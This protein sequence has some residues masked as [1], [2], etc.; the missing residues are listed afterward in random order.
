MRTAILGFPTGLFRFSLFFFVI[1]ALSLLWPKLSS[2]FVLHPAAQPACASLTFRPTAALATLNESGLLLQRLRIGD[3][4]NDGRPD[5]IAAVRLTNGRLFDD[6]AG[7]IAVFLAQANG[8]FQVGPGLQIPGRVDVGDLLLADFNGDGKLDLATLAPGVGL[9]VVRGDGL[10]GFFNPALYNFDST[11]TNGG[12]AALAA[13]DFNGD[14]RTDLAV[15]HSGNNCVYVLFS[16][17]NGFANA[18]RFTVG[19]Q[20]RA[21][22]AGDFNVDGRADLA[23]VN[24][25]SRNVTMLL[26]QAANQ[27]NVRPSFPV[28]GATGRA[29]ADDLNGDGKLDLVLSSNGMTLALL[30]FGDG[31]GGFSAPQPL[32]PP[33]TIYHGYPDINSLVSGDFN[34]DGQRDLALVQ[35]EGVLSTNVYLGLGAGQFAG[36]NIFAAPTLPFDLAVGDLNGDGKQ[37]LAVTG[38]V[39]GVSVNI[40]ALVNQTDCAAPNAPPVFT[41]QQPIELYPPGGEVALGRIQDAETPAAQL[42][43]SLHEAPAGLSFSQFR[44]DVN[45]GWVYAAVRVS[46]QTA[47][48]SYRATLRVADAGGRTAL[49]E[50]TVNV[51]AA[52]SP[53]PLPSLGNDPLTVPLDGSRSFR[54][55]DSLNSPYTGQVSMT[56]SPGFL[57]RVS[58]VSGSYLI[59]NAAPAGA[60]TLTLTAQTICGPP[61]T[62]SY[63]LMVLAL[64]E[65]PAMSFKTTALEVGSTGVLGDFNGDGVLDVASTFY[66]TY[67][68]RLGGFERN[69]QLVPYPNTNGLAPVALDKA[70][71]NGD[72]WLDLAALTQAGDLAILLND[73]T[74]LLQAP[75]LFGVASAYFPPAGLNALVTGDFNGDGRPDLVTVGDGTGKRIGVLLNQG[76]AGLPFD[77]V[78]YFNAGDNL[79]GLAT[80]DF[81]RD[82]KLDLA[83][84]G[85][86][87]TLLLGN[88]DGSF[89]EPQVVANASQ[90]LRHAVGDLNRDGLPDLVYVKRLSNSVAVMLNRGAGT[91][92]EP[93]AYFSGGLLAVAVVIGDLNQ[94]GNADLVVGNNE[95]GSVGI[96]FG[97]GAGDFAAPASYAVQAPL[98]AVALA[99][100][101][102]DGQLD[103][104]ASSLPPKVI[105]GLGQGRFD[106][107]R[108][109]AAGN[110][111]ELIV[112][113]DFTGDGLTDAVVGGQFTSNFLFLFP[114]QADGTFGQRIVLAATPLNEGP[115]FLLTADFDGDRRPDLA[116][117]SKGG[118]V[119]IL[120]NL[121]NGNFSPPGFMT[122]DR[123]ANYLAAADFN[124]D[125]R[126][127]LAVVNAAART[128]SL[129]LNNGFGG[130]AVVTSVAP[131]LEPVSVAGADLNADGKRDLIVAGAKGE[132]AVLPGDG[133]GGFGAATLMTVGTT[134][135]IPTAVGAVERYLLV[136][137]LNGDGK[138]DVVLGDNA[139]YALYVLLGNGAGGFAAPKQLYGTWGNYVTAGDYNGDGKLDLASNGLLLALGDGAGNFRVQQIPDASTNRFFALLDVNRDG[140]PDLLNPVNGGVQ[141][142]LN[143]TACAGTAAPVAAAAVSAA[144]FRGAGLAAEQLVTLFGPQLAVAVRNATAWPLPS[145]LGGTSVKVRDSVGV[146]R[147]A[148]LVFAAPTQLNLMIP[149]GTALGAA[150]IEVSIGDFVSAVAATQIVRVAP[151]LFTADG[152]GRGLPAAQVLRVRAAGSQQYEPVARYD[153]D[154]NRFV[155]VPIVL[156]AANEQVLLVLYGTG[157][158]G[159]SDLSSVA[160]TIGGV[161]VPVQYAGLLTGLAGVD[162]LNLP[163]GPALAGRGLVDVVVR[164]EGQA[165]N[166]VQVQL[167]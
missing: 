140:K 95:S 11:A 92:S 5:L 143:R 96:L 55:F 99:D 47:P 16:T 21:L 13:G 103:L 72:G 38:N 87:V 138:P 50:V 111:A 154:Q 139:S 77:G 166:V 35:N 144:D 48:G 121:G 120:R 91:F 53:P 100:F 61:V 58:A 36:A 104:L 158:R 81:N 57:G 74:G 122:T 90:V 126:P 106:A 113:A 141:V 71:F 60:H 14:G 152:S 63:T 116:T 127:D 43:A 142:S 49:A 44:V 56:A 75:V 40:G 3:V 112:T 88:G 102:R 41:P 80:G 46:C 51:L 45:G 128:V 97:N 8:A 68:N 132:F 37:D 135:P 137:E 42:T 115:V 52:L 25:G 9:A 2:T 150:T 15:A 85:E 30:L 160:A 70:D 79:A 123:G 12:L 83:L 125:G 108:L 34:G 165:A 109:Y 54:L 105:F 28:A 84:A 1:S 39:P 164:V 4:N 163:L 119:S 64:S 146:A 151:G 10:G 69:V 107:P 89:A 129:A 62:R 118:T 65:C 161:S 94:D 167:R 27:M 156:G 76:G 155:P 98:T 149:E 32:Q 117:A 31:Q 59:E 148:P 78:R 133:A 18:V 101:N 33:G 124:G 131:V 153:A 23:V 7:R 22:A 17:G 26:G 162:Q 20:P 159:R 66:L 147:F 29:L 86:G 67:G 19:V 93:V 136:T 114:G 82:G 6:G 24:G 145:H 73:R 110:R 157:W 130:F 134:L